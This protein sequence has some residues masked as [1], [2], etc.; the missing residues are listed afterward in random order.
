MLRTVFPDECSEKGTGREARIYYE[1]QK[2]HLVLAV[3]CQDYAI[4]RTRFVIRQH[5]VCHKYPYI[6]L[7]LS[8]D[9]WL[10]DEY[11]EVSE[12]IRDQVLTMCT[13]FLM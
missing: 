3:C 9:Y 1:T 11:L 13:V 8:W 6:A 5:T 2:K 10:N 4:N 12:C 7:G